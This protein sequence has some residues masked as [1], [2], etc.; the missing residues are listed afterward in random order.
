MITSHI[1][2][3]IIP[4]IFMLFLV[5]LFRPRGNLNPEHAQILV[6]QPKITFFGQFLGEYLPSGEVCT[7]LIRNILN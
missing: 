6:A 7:F 4:T 5:W 3:Q 1:L 2:I